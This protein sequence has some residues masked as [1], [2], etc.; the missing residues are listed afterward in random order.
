M[1]LLHRIR[2]LKLNGDRGVVS[3]DAT[4]TISFP[5]GDGGFGLRLRHKKGQRVERRGRSLCGRGSRVESVNGRRDSRRAPARSGEV[6]G[7]DD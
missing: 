5:I 4:L 2:A 7:E 3:T 1:T 6:V